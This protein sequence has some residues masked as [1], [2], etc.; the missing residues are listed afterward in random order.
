MISVIDQYHFLLSKYF[1]CG[2]TSLQTVVV[3]ET[4]LGHFYLFRK[5]FENHFWHCFLFVATKQQ[6]SLVI[7]GA[8]IIAGRQ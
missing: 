8:N 3:V 7:K 5:S 4:T 2:R 1:L 6:Q